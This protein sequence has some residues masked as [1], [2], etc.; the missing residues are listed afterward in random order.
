MESAATQEPVARSW[1]RSLASGSAQLFGATLASNAGSSGAW[2][3]VTRGLTPSANS[4]PLH[5]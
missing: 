3:V 4:G 5:S 1:K 2:V